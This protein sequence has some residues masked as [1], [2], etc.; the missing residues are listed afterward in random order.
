MSEDKVCEL[1][2]YERNMMRQPVGTF[3]ILLDP[4]TGY[5]A[6]G[7]AL[8]S[9]KDA[10]KK[11]TGRRIAFQRAQNA[12]EV[13][14]NQFVKISPCKNE[15]FSEILY[16]CESGFYAQ[17]FNPEWSDFERNLLEKCGHDQFL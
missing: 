14:K 7:V 9:D 5:A 11:S 15:N 13:R 17:V 16:G 2:Y 10:P 4:K 1:Y 3:C 6:R 12:L 8:C